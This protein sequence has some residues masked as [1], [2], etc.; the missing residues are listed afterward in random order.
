LPAKHAKHT[1]NKGG[2]LGS[3]LVASGIAGFKAG[4]DD[5]RRDHVAAVVWFWKR[6]APL[7]AIWHG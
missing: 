6:V 3:L 7:F 1:K 2:E 4:G 5:F